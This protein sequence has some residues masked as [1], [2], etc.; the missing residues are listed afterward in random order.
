MTHVPEDVVAAAAALARTER[1]TMYSV[2]LAAMA[3]YLHRGSGQEDLSIVSHVHWGNLLGVKGALGLFANPLVMR[4]RTGRRPTYRD[5]VKKVFG[6]VINAYRH[7][8]ANVVDLAPHTAF[9]LWFNYQVPGKITGATQIAPGLSAMR[10]PLPRF[11][12]ARLA[13]DLVLLL[14]NRGESC[15]LV[16]MY[17]TELFRAESATAF[18]RGYIQ[19]LEAMRRD[20]DAPLG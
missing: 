20:P 18:V 12:S 13:Y 1:T 15:G 17:N 8:G 4:I 6:V 16:L 5:L 9:R 3:A 14:H 19:E 7:G 2:L 11:T 10:A